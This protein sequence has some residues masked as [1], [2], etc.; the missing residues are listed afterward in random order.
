[1][2]HLGLVFLC[3]SLA[4]CGASVKKGETP[5][6]GGDDLAVEVGGEDAGGGEQD[7]AAAAGDDGGGQPGC[8]PSMDDLVGCGCDPNTTPRACWP[9]DADPKTRHVGTFKDGTQ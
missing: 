7:L 6:G 4:A 9:K 5:A 8:A 3:S 1:M 2:R